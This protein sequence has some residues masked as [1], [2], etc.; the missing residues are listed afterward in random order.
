MPP[1]LASLVFSII[2]KVTGMFT[3]AFSMAFDIFKS[4][5]K[6]AVYFQ[7]TGIA[8]ARQLG[9]SYEQSIA[10]TDT[11]TRR[12]KDLALAYGITKEQVAELQKTISDSTARGI[13]LSDSEADRLAQISKLVGNQTAGVFTDAIINTMGGQLSTMENAVSNAY[14]T[15]AKSGLNAAKFSSKVAQNLG[16][17]NK[18]AFRD[19][20]NS[21]TRM[22]ALSEKLGYNLSSIEA[23]AEKFSN[24]D[25]AIETS[26][27]LNMLGGSAG[28][29]G[30]NPLQMMYES[31]YDPEKFNKSLTDMLKSYGRYNRKTGMGEVSAINMDMIRE[32]SKQLGIGMNEAVSIAKNS[33][34][35]RE[36]EAIAGTYLN[37][38]A[39]DD[40]MKR[41]FI[42][43]KAQID[44]TTNQMYVTGENGQKYSMAELATPGSQG[45]KWLE[46]TYAYANKSDSEIMAE[47]AQKLTSIDEKLSGM[48]ESIY[49]T[50]AEKMM[51]YFHKL[52]G[53]LDEIKPAIKDVIIPVIRA[54]ADFIKPGIDFAIAHPIITAV[55]YGILSVF[56]GA[57][58]VWI[59]SYSMSWLR[60]GS[61]F[62]KV[63]S[64]FS[65]FLKGFG[66]FFKGFGTKI[67]TAFRGLHTGLRTIGNKL[68]SGVRGLSSIGTKIWNGL[69]GF[70]NV[71]KG[72]GGKIVNAVKGIG[73]FLKSGW[74]KIAQPAKNLAG[75]TGEALK[76]AGRATKGAARTAGQA[77][78]SGAQS[79]ARGTGNFFRSTGR[80]VGNAAR[81]TVQTFKDIG[82]YGKYVVEN[83]KAARSSGNLGKNL[84]NIFKPAAK[85]AKD[86][87]MYSSALKNA[88]NGLLLGK[89]LRA[90]KDVA[91][92]ARGAKVLGSVGASAGLGIAG[93][94][95]NTTTDYATKADLI[96]KN[97]FTERNLHR[98]G[99]MLEG[100]G[101]GAAVGSVVP[102]IGTAVGA[103]VGGVAGYGVEYVKQYMDFHEKT[104]GN[105]W[106]F[107]KRDVQEFGEEFKKGVHNAARLVNDPSYRAEIGRKIKNMFVNM[108]RDFSE[109]IGGITDWVVGAKN[110]VVAFARNFTDVF[111]A[112]ARI[113]TGDYVSDRPKKLVK[114]M[115]DFWDNPIQTIKNAYN[116]VTS[117]VKNV[118][119]GIKNFFGTIWETVKDALSKV[120]IDIGSIRNEAKNGAEA[121]ANG[122]IVGGNSYV[123]DKI[124]TKLNSGELVLNTVQTEKLFTALKAVDNITSIVANK[125]NGVSSFLPKSSPEKVTSIVAKPIGEKEYIYKPSKSEL[126]GSG[127]GNVKVNDI[128]VK[129]SGEIKLSGNGGS[130]NFNSRDLLN[131]QSF[132]RSLKDL[133]KESI[134][135]D[136]QGG[137]VMNDV[138]MM[139]GMPSNQS[140]FGKFSR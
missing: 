28:L 104:G 3:S 8:T 50:F 111:E 38:I 96:D 74:N 134:S 123:G 108:G 62:T 20:L 98:G 92:I 85:I 135:R 33:S 60:A 119:E 36:K 54:I 82:V 116:S 24:F 86:G 91:S 7:K 48:A 21:L 26:A 1:F 87:Q 75:K 70:G 114:A 6:N 42:L 138:S 124:L 118:F 55:G 25:T 15:A 95:I 63:G 69:K 67:A 127:A 117:L 51:P 68:I 120:G 88:N 93:M 102:V 43:N 107:M 45:A 37:R 71:L 129:I 35:I 61:A 83:A 130:V 12:T 64:G 110:K 89:N 66:N 122:G 79:A 59:A 34:V 133:I 13:M 137:R 99:A 131:D 97:S 22:T 19:G 106:D 76:N 4:G 10:Y 29:Y 90:A 84:I 140:V 27:H 52:N 11:L 81:G 65:N 136:M 47:S 100:A 101:I 126:A 32:I 31:M 112:M 17:A 23:A 128:N 53:Y 14:A 103:A 18:F 39:G 9:M 56:A 78:K 16:L 2:G 94:A 113:L 72:I 40:Q 46:S 41:D 132:V 115:L 30:S 5:L 49:A 44:T 121:H 109:W 73:D 125:R 139:R 105:L 58:R 77:I 80:A 57:F